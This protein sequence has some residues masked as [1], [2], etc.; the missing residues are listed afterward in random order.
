MHTS[1]YLLPDGLSYTVFVWDEPSNAKTYG[2]NI[3][4]AA[5][6]HPALRPFKAVKAIALQRFQQESKGELQ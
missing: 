1:F 3:A 4:E 6:L 5:A 2:I